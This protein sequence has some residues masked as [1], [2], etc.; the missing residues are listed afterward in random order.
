MAL[1]KYQFGD[2]MP[3]L[4]KRH[5]EDFARDVSELALGTRTDPYA[6]TTNSIPDDLPVTRTRIN[7]NNLTD[8]HSGLKYTHLNSRRNLA[9]KGYQENPASVPP[10]LLVKRAGNYEIADGT[11]RVS[12]AIEVG[13]ESIPAWVV[14]SP[15][16]E[17]H[18]GYDY[19]D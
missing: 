15:L 3:K 6:E 4:K 13:K 2:L 17:P 14:H 12:A 16:S 10:I 7:P 1:S 18:P 11:H 19:Y 9:I 8:W 5:G